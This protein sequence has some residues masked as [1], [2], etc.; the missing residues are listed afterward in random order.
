MKVKVIELGKLVGN[1]A[2]PNRMGRE[3]FRKLVG[4]IR[5]TG[6]YEPI[7]VRVHPKIEGSYEIIN[8][9]HRRAALDEIG[10]SEAMCV[11]W[12]VSDEEADILLCTLNRL[13]GCDEVVKRA[14]IIERLAGKFS[15]KEIAGLLPESARQVERLCGLRA[16]TLTIAAGGNVGGPGAQVFFLDGQQK[17]VVERALKKAGAGRTA[18]ERAEGIVRI[19]GEY[20]GECLKRGSERPTFN[21]ERSTSN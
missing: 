18:R 9:H 11:V 10:A 6:V 2:N 7:A 16:R 8:G 3:K 14:A 1:E 19:C 21:I 5:R 12:D 20:L 13:G 17:E 4:H 15:V